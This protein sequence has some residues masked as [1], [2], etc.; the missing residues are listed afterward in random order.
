MR[1]TIAYPHGETGGVRTLTCQGAVAD[2]DSAVQKLPERERH[3]VRAAL[4][5]I[6][7]LNSTRKN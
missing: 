7:E 4:Q 1:V 5:R 2:I 6:R 3:L